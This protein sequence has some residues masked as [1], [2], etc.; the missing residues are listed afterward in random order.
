[1]ELLGPFV[2]VGDV[3]LSATPPGAVASVRH[4]GPYSGLG[5]AHEAVRGWC[6]ANDHNLAGPN[7]EIYGHWQ[8]EWD[9]DPSLICTDV[10]YLV[11]QG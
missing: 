7:W 9:L 3:V 1:V 2:E 11:A 5:A 4:M 8:S 10:F 6:R